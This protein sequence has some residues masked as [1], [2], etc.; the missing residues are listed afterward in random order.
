M[1]P[2]A[3]TQCLQQELIDGLCQ[4]TPS[5]HLLPTRLWAGAEGYDSRAGTDPSP[6]VTQICVLALMGP[7]KSLLQP[8]LKV[9]ALHS[10]Q[11]QTSLIAYLVSVAPSRY[12]YQH[13]TGTIGQKPSALT[14]R[15]YQSPPRPCRQP[16]VGF[17]GSLWM[18]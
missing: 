14:G 2:P 7:S 12:C 10:T 3:V 17:E 16:M 5:K 8:L 4:P 11:P 1:L 9:M 13:A 6:R 15:V 18:T